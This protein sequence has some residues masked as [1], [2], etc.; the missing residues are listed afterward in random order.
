M[1]VVIG[2]GNLAR[3]DDGIGVEVVRRLIERFGAQDLELRLIDAGTAGMDVMYQVRGAVQVIIVDACRSGSEAGAVF[4][5]PGNEAQTPA[6][7]GF[8]QHG[9][10]W[11]HA[12][13]AGGKM[14][15]ADFLRHVEVFLVEAKSRFRHRPECRGRTRRAA[16]H[17]GNLRFDS[18]ARTCRQRGSLA[19]KRSAAADQRG[20]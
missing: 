7:P 10:R 14:F 2:C 5:L 3:S 19:A 1:L 8:T 9:L 17:R 18:Y 13:Y 12:L 15:G 6:E 4:R 16:G 11:D 20:L